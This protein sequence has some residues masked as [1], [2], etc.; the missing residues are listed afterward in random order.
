MAARCGAGDD[1]QGGAA[2]VADVRPR[3]APAERRTGRRAATA[4]RSLQRGAFRAASRR[5][6]HRH[7]RTGALARLSLNA[8]RLP[9]PARRALD[10]S[11]LELPVTNSFRSI[12]VR[13][14]ELVAAF[15]DAAGIARGAAA[16]IAPCRIPFEPRAGTGSHATEAPRGLLYHR[17]V[18]G[19]DGLVAEATIVPPTSQNQAAIEAELRGILP[20]ALALDD[21]A[22][23]LE[24]EHVIRNH[25]PCIS[26]ATHFLR[27]AIDRTPR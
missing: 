2:E 16:E 18:I 10:A 13:S 1:W 19:D 25:D 22:A 9:E 11:G 4:S 6:D 24:C 3:D 26:C 14:I 7:H 8:D 5:C 15:A 12:V 17:Y 20:S 27:L 21:A 23:T